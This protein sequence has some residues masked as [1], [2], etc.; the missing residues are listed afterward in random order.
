MGSTRLPG[1][2]LAE[3]A[4]RPMLRFMLDR[5]R[6]L[7][8]DE[9]VV[10]TS[11]LPRDDPV[12]EIAA[13]AGVGVVRGPEADVLRRFSL[14]LDRHPADRVVRLTADCPLSDPGLVAEV[15]ALADH[16]GADYASNAI[17]RTFPD[18]LDIEVITADALRTADREAT[19]PAEREHVTPFVYRRTPR[20][21]VAALIGTEALGAERWTVD[22]AADLE[23]LR[24]IVARLPDPVAAGWRDALAVAGRTAP[25]RRRELRLRPAL[26]SDAA[27]ARRPMP[28]WEGSTRT[29]VAERD[30]AAVGWAEVV[31]VD[32]TGRVTTAGSDDDRKSIRALL[33][34]T[35]ADDPQVVRLAPEF[36]P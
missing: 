34:R 4:G 22:T 16:T 19:D 31:F 33:A 5:L 35:L 11:D 9:T 10:A 13:G 30:G 27:A 20:F 12:A 26:A 2:V 6:P 25:M 36:T 28:L 24:G 29:W 8:V 14:A 15:L 32:G 17:M 18:G 23:R 7:T 1:K 21:R 3:L